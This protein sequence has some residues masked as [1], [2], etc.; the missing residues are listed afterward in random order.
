MNH[1]SA[2][3]SSFDRV[4]TLVSSFAVSSQIQQAHLDR[5]AQEKEQEL[6]QELKETRE[7]LAFVTSQRDRAQLRLN[8]VRDQL[9]FARDA[10]RAEIHWASDEL[11][12]LAFLCGKLTEV[13][14]HECAQRKAQE[15]GRTEINANDLVWA[16]EHIGPKLP[17]EVA[18]QLLLLCEKEEKVPEK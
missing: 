17:P 3:V 18:D 6:T 12:R 9:L 13:V 1:N 7:A 8:L 2:I 4:P 5:K 14:V 11:M 10:A 15:D 16:V